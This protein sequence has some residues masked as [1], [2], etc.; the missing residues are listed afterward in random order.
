MLLQEVKSGGEGIDSAADTAVSGKRE[1]EKGSSRRRREREGGREE[2][3]K[4]GR[5]M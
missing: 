3:F 5:R 4:N 1:A 2:A